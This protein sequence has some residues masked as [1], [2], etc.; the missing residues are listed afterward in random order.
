[1]RRPLAQDELE[2]HTVLRRR[3]SLD[4]TVPAPHGDR[5][6][7]ASSIGTEATQVGKEI[8]WARGAT[9]PDAE[10]HPVHTFDLPLFGR[11]K[12]CLPRQAFPS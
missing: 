12:H 10:G 8:I 3:L 1:M 5:V 11:G 4:H 2:L 6:A 9:Y 7:L